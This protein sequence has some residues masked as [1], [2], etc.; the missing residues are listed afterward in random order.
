MPPIQWTVKGAV[1]APRSCALSG[2]YEDYWASR[3]ANPL[4][5]LPQTAGWMLLVNLFLGFF[6]FL[7]LQWYLENIYRVAPWIPFISY[8]RIVT[9][10]D[11]L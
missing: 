5:K 9:V 1:L 4:H 8:D 6:F 2:R 3:R 10:I 11:V 7:Q